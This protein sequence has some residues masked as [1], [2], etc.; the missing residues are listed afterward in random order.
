MRW[1]W[2]IACSGRSASRRL[3]RTPIGSGSSSLTER[4][5]HTV[6]FVH[7]IA[8]IGGAER[9]LLVMLERLPRRGYHPIVVCPDGGPLAQKLARLGVE[10]R[11]AP[12]PPWRKLF[13]YP[14]RAGAVRALRDVIAAA[15]PALIHVNDIWWVPQ[16]LR[17]AEGLPHIPIAAHVRQEIEPAK[18][19]RYELERADLVLPVS[20]QIQRSLEQ[21][22]VRPERLRTLYSG[23]DMARV[24]DQ[25]DGRDA[26]RRFGIPAEA[27]VLGTVANLFERKGYEVMIQALPEIVTASPAAHCLIVGSGDAAYEARLRATVEVLGLERRVHF[28]GFQESVHPCLAAMD[29]YVHPA[30]MEGFGIAVLEA[31]AMRKPVVATTTGGLPEIVQDGETGMLVP[32][33]DAGALAG[34]VS[35]LLQNPGRRKQ[36]GEAGRARVAAHFTVEAMMDRLTSGYE[37]LI[38]QAAP[39][40]SR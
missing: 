39:A 2:A 30:L 22:G 9:E 19:R 33:G 36:F 13:A 38:G 31:M 8:E 7:G 14:Q 6:L 1:R 24:M 35:S 3:R 12:M 15:R 4:R 5:E 17:A 40:V 26:R 20:R 18:A 27:L 32:S 10:T 23:L 21:G 29:L 34:A 28:A 16:A 25:A 37:T 11:M